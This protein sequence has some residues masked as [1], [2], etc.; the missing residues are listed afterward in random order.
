MARCS[1][2]FGLP[3]AVVALLCAATAFGE[4][5]VAVDSPA[6]LVA[7][8]PSFL[9]QSPGAR[10]DGLLHGLLVAE[11]AREPLVLVSQRQD[12]HVVVEEQLR[13]HLA[14]AFALHHRWLFAL[15]VPLVLRQSGEGL[16][17]ASDLPPASELA[18]LGDPSLLARG[19]VLGAA[20]GW[21]LGLGARVALPLA[22]AT[23]AG[24]PGPQLGAFVSTGRQ[25]A[26]SFSAFTAGFT[27]RRAQT[28]PGILPTRVGSSLDLALAGGFA[29]DR[30]RR[31]HLGPELALRATVGN[32]ASLLDPRSSLAVLLLHLRHRPLSGP[33]ELGV[34]FGPS[35]GRTPG[36][37]DY[38]VLLSVAFSPA[39]LAPPPDSDADRVPDEGDMCPSLPG[40]A[41][42]D[43][44]M[45]G[46]PP[47]P[48]DAEG[49]GIP[50][51]IDACPRTVG[52]PSLDV[53][54]HGCPKPVDRDHDA[55]A[56][57]DDACPE[58]AGPES[59]DPA[60]RGCP[61]PL[62]S[63]QLEEH[64]ISMS[65]QAQF[66]TGTAVIRE[67]SSAL[68]QKVADLLLAHPEITQC[69]IA[70][71]TDDRGSPSANLQL[72]QAR[73]RAVMDWLVAHGVDPQRL[74]ARGYGETRPIADN[75]TEQ[76][77]ASNR[78]VELRITG[79]SGPPSE[80]PGP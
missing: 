22:T 48:S 61:R 56:D 32:G 8:D 27:W 41:S 31:T 77:R 46:C 68:L 64:R 43:P 23:Y 75:S 76:G 59:A 51:T 11:Y 70:G 74:N 37:A 62:P 34:A 60:Q 52:E 36:A 19:R 39:V 53:R 24:S 47:V 72:S 50:D 30:A 55:I 69:E 78:R 18:A 3:G 15:D 57:A 29:L 67:E 66:E 45:H 14:A 40:E 44:M 2:R 33:L 79:R 1:P 21:A 25:R 16:G 13:L 73:A 80:E 58:Q 10:G 12:A 35:L 42:E 28:L 26:G 65:E 63:A 5:R 20:D 49:D 9:A 17:V 4:P 71:H 54:R 6:S 7:G 38:R